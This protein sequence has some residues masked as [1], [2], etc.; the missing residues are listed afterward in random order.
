METGTRILE[1]GVAREKARWN[2][3]DQFWSLRSASHADSLEAAFLNSA[4]GNYEQALEFLKRHPDMDREFLENAI[5]G[6][7]SNVD[8]KFFWQA[9]ADQMDAVY[10]AWLQNIDDD[11]SYADLALIAYPDVYYAELPQPL[12][13]RDGSPSFYPRSFYQ[14]G[15][16]RLERLNKAARWL[17]KKY[18]IDADKA[19]NGLL[20]LDVAVRQKYLSPQQY[21]SLAVSLARAN[22]IPASYAYRPNMI[23]V[24]FDDGNYGY[25]DLEKCAP[26]TDPADKKAF[27]TL[28][29]L[30]SDISGAPLTLDF[31]GN[32]NLIRYQDG[33]FYWSEGDPLVYEANGVYTIRAP[34]GEYYLNAGYRV[35]DSQ[36]AFQMKH[37]DLSSADSLQVEVVLRDYPRGWSDGVYYK[38]PD[39]L[40]E[41]DTTGY[42]IFLFGNHDQENS[43]RLAEKLRGL[44][45]KFLWLGHE[46]APQTIADYVF[47]PGWQKWVEEDQRNRVRTIT[48]IK[49]EDG[50]W[51]GSYE[52]LWDRLPE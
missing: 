42:S 12:E 18:K 28:R 41:A 2:E 46:P 34:K 36:T 25:Y 17:K 48:L 32:L 27:T 5:A 10:Q 7:R 14:N 9:D 51:I 6:E 43:I 33:S 22:G 47:C 37:L 15:D 3:L 44:G 24:G 29:V 19:L 45:R 21:S 40:A 30:S 4:R 35:S 13:C 39:L 11:I 31:T 23:Q 8:P 26:E 16:T 49:N 20:P 50:K 52:G 38:I 1:R